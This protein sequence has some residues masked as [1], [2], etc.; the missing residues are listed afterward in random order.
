MQRASGIVGRIAAHFAPVLRR[1]VNCGACGRSNVDVTHMVAGP[2]VYLCDRCIEQ[3]ARQLT[4]RK[5]APDAVRCQ[6]CRQHR[7]KDEVTAVGGV[8][9]CA[10]C[11]G[12]METILAKAAQSSRPAT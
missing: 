6:F 4:P 11:L 9:V 2:N 12:L 7:A 1:T 3:A 10:D 5:P 8:A